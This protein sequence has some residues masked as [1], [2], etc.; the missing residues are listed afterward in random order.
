MYLIQKDCHQAQSEKDGAKVKEFYRLTE[1]WLMATPC[2]IYKN[3]GDDTTLDEH[4]RKSLFIFPKGRYRQVKRPLQDSDFSLSA[5]KHNRL[6][7]VNLILQHATMDLWNQDS[8]D[9]FRQAYLSKFA[10]AYPIYFK[11]RLNIFGSQSEYVNT[12]FP[13]AVISL[14]LLIKQLAHRDIKLKTQALK[15]ID[16]G[17]IVPKMKFM[18]NVFKV[19]HSQ[20]NV[21][22][23]NL[24]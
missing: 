19:S 1:G 2:T 16:E 18:K 24:Q 8:C 3:P 9:I 6:D 15:S 5:I 22:L 21:A 7:V 17:Y 13:E 10:K 20:I 12:E 14:R 4:Q 11:D 23:V